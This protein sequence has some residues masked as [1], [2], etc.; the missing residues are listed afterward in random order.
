MHHR[1]PRDPCS[2]NEANDDAY[3]CNNSNNFR[4]NHQDSA[5]DDLDAGSDSMFCAKHFALFR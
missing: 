4:D 2:N 5:N 3:T 1:H